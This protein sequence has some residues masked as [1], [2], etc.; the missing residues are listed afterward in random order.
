[1]TAFLSRSIFFAIT[2]L[3]LTAQADS[4]MCGDG[5]TS[6]ARQGACSHHGGI[7]THASSPD[8]VPRA[9]TVR[10]DD[11]T[12]SDSAGRGACSHHGGVQK[13]PPITHRDVHPRP[14][15]DRDNSFAP[16]HHRA[17][18]RDA[19]RDAPPPSIPDHS[20]TPAR[21][22]QPTA[23]CKDGT[24]SYSAHHSGTCSRHGG[25]AQW[26]GTR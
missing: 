12:V 7:A 5:T 4:I 11:G 26:A 19:R 24:L 21:V 8:P 17:D 23:R 16:D 3:T 18:E 14:R 22:D 1:M 6:R 2:A 20:T 15:A 13:L 10:C 25:V 9:G